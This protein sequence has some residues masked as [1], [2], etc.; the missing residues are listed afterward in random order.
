[1]HDLVASSSG[2]AAGMIAMD[3]GHRHGHPGRIAG[4]SAPQG[5]PLRSGPRGDLEA[6]KDR[7][8]PG[9]RGPLPGG[10]VPG[11]PRYWMDEDSLAAN[12]TRKRLVDVLGVL[13]HT[14]LA[15]P[16]FL[17]VEWAAYRTLGDRPVRIAVIPA[18]VRDRLALPLPRRGRARPQASIRLDRRRALRGLGR[19]DLLRLG[20]E[21]VFD[22]RRGGS[23]VYLMGME[24]LARPATGPG[25]RPG[26]GRR[27]DRLVLA[28]VGVRPRGRR[29]RL[30]GLRGGGEDG[31]G[32]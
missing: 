18:P 17:V 5:G 32:P 12:I 23:R 25:R 2:M 14:Q 8:H 3:K 28:S 30:A 31:E 22:R 15:P 7:G 21:A 4:R 10:A 24:M 26:G 29:D 13:S 11:Q 1:M 16:G 6:A 27:H 20:V 9:P 19:P